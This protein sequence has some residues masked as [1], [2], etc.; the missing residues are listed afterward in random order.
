M[1]NYGERAAELFSMGYNCAQAVAGAFAERLGTELGVMM[2]LTSS[3]GGGMAG[4]RGVCGAVSG[5]LLV[6][7]LAKGYSDPEAKQE[8]A[9]H[10]ALCR[11]LMEEFR[12]C[13]GSVV[14]AELIAA[15]RESDDKRNHCRE[16]CRLAADIVSKHID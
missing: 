3:F 5:M 7:G 12:Q 8:K 13:K 14:C 11:C 4:T 15:R 6:V 9:D 1:T 2:K 10:Y 16:F